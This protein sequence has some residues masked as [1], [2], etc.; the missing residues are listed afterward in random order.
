MWSVAWT[1]EE[2][3]EHAKSLFSDA[4]GYD[5]ATTRSAPGRITIVGEHT[6]YS[7]GVSLATVTKQASY[8]AAA[9]RDD[10]AVRLVWRDGDGSV[11][12]WEGTLDDARP[13]G[14]GN[15]VVRAL[16]AVWALT[17]RGYVGGGLDLALESCLPESAGLAPG[18]SD[19]AAFTLAIDECWGLALGS[20]PEGRAELAAVCVDAEFAFSGVPTAGVV[21]HTIVRC[22]PGQAL[23]LDFI[24]REPSVT[25]Q[26]LYFPE[27]G[28]AL[29][30]IDTGTPSTLTLDE[31]SSRWAQVE[32][33][34][35]ALDVANLRE[36]ADA[37]HALRRVDA[38]LDDTARRRARHVVTEIAR[39]RLVTAELSGT[40]PAHERFVSIGKALYRSHASLA[41]D[42]EMSNPMLDA[43]VD[44]A[45]RAGALG[46][47][48]VE[49]GFGSAAFALVRK[50]QTETTARHI[51][52]AMVEAGYPPPTFS[53]V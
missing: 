52:Q 24:E 30:L 43:A 27:Y 11:Q 7:A 36:V 51:N 47:R 34:C 20:S 6:D 28:L 18:V 50:A 40:A 3:A 23:L 31:Y 2:G 48:I 4:F 13:R 26:P 25:E 14:R 45:F 39:V 35:I 29:L 21:Q 41:L 5:A 16:G 46:A 37:P 1:P 38:L 12:R 15:M 9:A 17:E 10:D 33:A 32:Q 22:P 8:V 49:G 42:Y 19:S 44:G 53:L